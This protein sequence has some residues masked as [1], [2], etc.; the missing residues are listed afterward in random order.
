MGF[1]GAGGV[2]FYLLG[3]IQ[4]LQYSRLMTAFC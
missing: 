1:V 4:M 2:G 3:C